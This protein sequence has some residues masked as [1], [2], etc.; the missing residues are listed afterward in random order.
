MGSGY[1]NYGWTWCTHIGLRCLS[2]CSQVNKIMVWK[3]C[4]FCRYENYEPT[5]LDVSINEG[6]YD[7]IDIKYHLA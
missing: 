5:L 7:S 3:Y 1:G 6:D 4:Y 2:I